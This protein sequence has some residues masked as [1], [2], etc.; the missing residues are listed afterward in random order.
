MFSKEDWEITRENY[1]KWWKGELK[2]PIIKATIQNKVNSSIELLSQKNCNDLKLSAED[3]INRIDI[4][5]KNQEYLGDAFPYV[6][7]DSFGSGVVAAF[8][9]QLWIIQQQIFT[10]QLMSGFWTQHG[11]RWST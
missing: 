6:S 8:L 11:V 7:F 5:L 3:I 9:E 10:F 2:R 4:E 1:T